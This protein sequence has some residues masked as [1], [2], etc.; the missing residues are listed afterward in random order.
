VLLLLLTS[1][2][3]AQQSDD[4]PSIESMF[5]SLSSESGG[6]ETSLTDSID[7]MMQSL[8]DG[9]PVE[10][11]AQSVQTAITGPL[12]VEAVVPEINK[13]VVEAIDKQTNRYSPRLKLD[14]E[15]F[16]SVRRVF[17][18]ERI[19]KHLQF[20]LRLDR[21]VGIEYQDRTVCLRGTV[22]TERQKE[23]AALILRLE[24]GV[25]AVKNELVVAK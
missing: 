18:A 16:P 15:S 1:T 24:P 11:T 21:P 17:P 7:K 12:I 8:S 19:A 3:I 6:K 20:R 4:F 5:S 9:G 22:S 14:G 23:L 25:D 10:N 2:V 13:E